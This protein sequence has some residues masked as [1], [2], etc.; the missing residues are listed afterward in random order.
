MTNKQFKQAMLRGQGRCIQAAQATPEQY[1]NTV[2][3][4]CSHVLYFD[5]QCEGTR[6][7]FVY[8]L[9]QCYAD[10][11]PFMQALQRNLAG[12][13][14]S[15]GWKLC[16]L[17]ELLHHCS[18]DGEQWAT[19]ALWAQ[20]EQL[21]AALSAKKRRPNRY[22]YERDDFETLCQTLATTHAAVLKIATDIGNLYLQRSFY[23]GFDFNTVYDDLDK[24]HL[25]ALVKQAPTSP[26]IAE[27]LRVCREHAQVLKSRLPPATQTPPKSGIALSVWLRR[28]GDPAAISP[29][30]TAYLA[31]TDCHAR[32]EA[33]AVFRRC[34]YP[35]NPTP[36]L[37]D[38]QSSCEVLQDTAWQALE[39]IRHPLVREFA[40]QHLDSHP[41]GAFVLFIKNYEPQDASLLTHLVRTFP[42]DFADTTDWHGI[43]LSVLNMA[44]FAK[45]HRAHCCA[46]FLKPPTALAAAKMPC[47]KWQ[48]AACSQ[49]NFYKSACLTATTKF[50]PMPRT[51]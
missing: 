43:H 2:L 42:V 3:W 9:I 21:L 38:A 51:V 46:I 1:R 6:A 47:S 20:Y 7:W 29:Y 5:A 45:R 12:G 31:Q 10:K 23:E 17:V 26:A 28:N 14:F 13:K 33:L 18:C 32:A 48:S 40:I 22:F 15:R 39:H 25:S 50:G 11:T 34:P 37:A 36:I 16:Y 49:P 41:Y 24:R 8:Q 27:Y 19:Q 44:D 35:D 30:V 4:A